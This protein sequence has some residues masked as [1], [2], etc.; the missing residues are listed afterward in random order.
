M[1]AY[2]LVTG[3][4]FGLIGVAHLL[5]LVLEPGH[6]LSAHPWFFAGNLTLFIVGGGLAV[7]ALRLLR[8]Q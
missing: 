6:S 5:R 8:A 4:I 3:A 1:K 2:L 7:W